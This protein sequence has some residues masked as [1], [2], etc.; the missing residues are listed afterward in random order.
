[1]PLPAG[2]APQTRPGYPHE[3]ARGHLHSAS[4]M[5]RGTCLP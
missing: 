2:I 3:M 1:L 4:S 5:A